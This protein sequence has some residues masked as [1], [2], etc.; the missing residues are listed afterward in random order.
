MAIHYH[1]DQGTILICD[2]VGFVKPEMQ[3]RRP[4]VVVS[5]RL[6]NRTG[7]C[8]VVPMSTT[9]PIKI[10]PYH[11]KLHTI[12][13]LPEPYS[14]PSH[15]VKAD[16]IY[17]VAFERLSLMTGGKDVSG[18]RIYDDR[19]IDKADLLKIQACILHGIGL[20]ALTDHL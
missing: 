17:T 10:E 2:F 4:V 5:P 13:P 18:K 19:V 20:T 1:P 6:R 12:P 9:D 11:H 8:V 15:W 7:L 3:K 16:M 14:S